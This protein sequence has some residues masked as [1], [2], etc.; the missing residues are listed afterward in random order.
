LQVFSLFINLQHS[1]VPTLHGRDS[2]LLVG[3]LFLW[4][5][6]GRTQGQ[7]LGLLCHTRSG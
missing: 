3:S 4:G 2:R 6:A 1:I 7:S 5:F